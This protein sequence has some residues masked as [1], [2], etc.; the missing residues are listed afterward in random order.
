MKDLLNN[1]K[2]VRLLVLFAIILLVDVLFVSSPLLS[3]LIIVLSFI[4][5]LFKFCKLNV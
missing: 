3:G 2:V 4:Y 1:K 5:I